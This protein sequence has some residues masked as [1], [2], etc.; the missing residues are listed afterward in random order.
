ME[1]FKEFLHSPK[2]TAIMGLVA[3]IFILFILI[4]FS[5]YMYIHS[6]TFGLIIYF[7]IIIKKPIAKSI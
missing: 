4:I 2:K 3:S 6:S 5:D 7:S 1:E